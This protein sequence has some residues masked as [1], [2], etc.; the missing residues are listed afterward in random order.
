[1]ELLY[2]SQVLYKVHV[3]LFGDGEFAAFHLI[4][5]IGKDEYVA[6]E[7]EVLLVVGQ[8]VQM[9]TLVLFHIHG[10]L[11]IEAIEANGI[12]SDGRGE[13][14]LQQ[15]HLVVVDIHI[16]KHILEDGGEYISCL[17]QVVDTR[18]VLPFDNALLAVRVLAVYLLRQCFVHRDGQYQFFVVLAHLHL[19]FH[20]RHLLQLGCFQLFGG[21]VVEGQC[22][23]LVLVIL[24]V[25][26]VF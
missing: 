23:L 14:I 3:A 7:S 21:D 2:H 20:P 15:S 11:D 13:G 19:V 24:V 18:R 26:L 10:V 6:S 5:G 1:M 12:L 16:G 22:Q 17:K 8:K 9:N 25:I 4:A